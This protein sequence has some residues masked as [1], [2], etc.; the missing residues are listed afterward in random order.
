MNERERLLAD[1]EYRIRYWRQPG[2]GDF[3]PTDLA[4]D[5]A[6]ELERARAAIAAATGGKQ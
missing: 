3:P 2:I 5:F 6:R 1:L 4:E